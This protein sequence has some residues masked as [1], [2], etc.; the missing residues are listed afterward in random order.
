MICPMCAR[1]KT[2]SPESERGLSVPKTHRDS[3]MHASVR[4]V[5]LPTHLPPPNKKK[6]DAPY[7]RCGAHLS[8]RH[9]SKLIWLGRVYSYTFHQRTQVDRSYKRPDARDPSDSYTIISLCCGPCRSLNS[10]NRLQQAE[11]RT[12]LRKRLAFSKGNK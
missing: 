3:V 5:S 4:R 10:S 6:T 8:T 2:G 11:T 7:T 1:M 12:K 9:D